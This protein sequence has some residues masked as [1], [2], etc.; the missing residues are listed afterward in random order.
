MELLLPRRC[1]GCAR[2]GQ[3]LCPECRQ[4]FRTPPS[5]V[6][7]AVDTHA[8]VFSLGPYDD[9][10]RAVILAMKERQNLVVREF[11]GRVLQA[12]IATL[13]ARGELPWSVTLVPAPTRPRNAR[14][15][16]GDH[17]T[18]CAR[19]TGLPV[20][21]VLAHGRVRDSVGLDAAARRRNL[22]GGVRLARIPRGPV[23]LIDDIVT[24]G[25]TLA[26]AA[27]VLY[28]ARVEVVAGVTIA[29][30]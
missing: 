13:Q 9:I 24:T 12:G 25:A 16:G 3:V 8:P 26:A 2:P 7:P 29:A 1:A 19:A 11:M 10:R 5:R 17:V 4:V 28:S 6:V 15:R 14:L 23:V 27:E 30:A 20:S 18:D 21:A 22:A